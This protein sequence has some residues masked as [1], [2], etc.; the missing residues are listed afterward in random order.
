MSLVKVY[1]ENDGDVELVAAIRSELF[2]DIAGALKVVAE[3]TGKQMTIQEQPYIT[4]N[5]IDEEI[6]Y[7]IEK[8]EQFAADSYHEFIDEFKQQ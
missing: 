1:Y 6:N 5:S 4:L 7:Q 3:C 2:H 8:Q